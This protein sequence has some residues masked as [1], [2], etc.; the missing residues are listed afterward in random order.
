MDLISEKLELCQLDKGEI[1]H[2]FILSIAKIA[3]KSKGRYF[4]SGQILGFD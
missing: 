3:S 1:A 2:E 4:I